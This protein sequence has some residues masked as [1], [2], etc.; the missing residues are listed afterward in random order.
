MNFIKLIIAMLILYVGFLYYSRPEMEISA[1]NFVKIIKAG[2]PDFAISRNKVNGANLAYSAVNNNKRI[3]IDYI[4]FESPEAA[5]LYYM[6][7]INSSTDKHQQKISRDIRINKPTAEKQSYLDGYTYKIAI[8]A[9]NTVIV[10]STGDDNMLNV[11]DI[12]NELY[13]PV[14]FDFSNIESYKLKL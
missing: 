7:F 9:K 12:F 3:K 6:D 14:E 4:N 5:H 11:N 1:D 8:Y 13:K 2:S 10:S